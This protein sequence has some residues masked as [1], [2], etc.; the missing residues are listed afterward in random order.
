[1]EEIDPELIEA[2]L[3]AGMSE[4]DIEELINELLLEQ[5]MEEEAMIAFLQEEADLKKELKKIKKRV[6]EREQIMFTLE[7]QKTIKKTKPHKKLKRDVAVIK[8]LF[9]VN[10]GK[11]GVKKAAVGTA[12]T[13]T[14]AIGWE[15]V[16]IILAVLIVALLTASV[17]IAF[18]S[19]DGGSSFNGI[20]GKDFYGVRMVYKDEEKSKHKIIEDY[21]DLV[22]QGVELA[23]NTT[24]S[25][26]TLT[27]NLTMPSEDFNFENFNEAEFA[28]QYPML[29]QTV[30]K[31]SQTVNKADN[32][33]EAPATLI[34]SVAGIKYF[35][36]VS[37]DEN[38]NGVDDI[39]EALQDAVLTA[40]TF[41]GADGTTLSQTDIDNAHN[42]IKNSIS[43][44]LNDEKLKIRTEKLF[45][46]DYILEEDDDTVTG[47]TKENYVALIFMPK[48]NVEFTGF[49]FSAVASDL[50]NLKVSMFNNGEEIYI[51]TDNTNLSVE[52]GADM[53][54]LYS[55][56]SN[57]NIEAST[58]A[59][60]DTNNLNQFNK[61][62]SLF[63]I[64]KTADYSIY[65]E[66]KTNENSLKYFTIKQNGV[67]VKMENDS[68]FG[69]VEMETGWLA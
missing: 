7:Q 30:L 64:V 52:D 36:L 57:L 46:K 23:E 16:L 1:M 6:I 58:F 54:F 28:G 8:G 45:I 60:I 3:E 49:S 10:K 2:L 53:F 18:T 31:I 42:A 39:T 20:N 27:V 40:S 33:T 67:L 56:A 24:L 48:K 12:G 21:I 5:Q 38:S 51:S 37:V 11:K 62:T 9:E 69:F 19:N 15:V 55:T 41:E 63:D 22:G 34:D 66:E 50:T 61:E 32:G 17:V 43:T 59:D 14:A 29:Y 13:G 26:V 4:E 65:L 47:V 44:L 68:K 35:G 25:N